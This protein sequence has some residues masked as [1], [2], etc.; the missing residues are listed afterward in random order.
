MTESTR[1]L[2]IK[3]KALIDTPSKWCRD[4]YARDAAGEKIKLV[5]DPR[6]V[7]WCIMGALRAVALRCTDRRW[8][9]TYTACS[10]VVR[11]VSSPSDFVKFNDDPATTHADI[12]ALFD[13]AI[14]SCDEDNQN[15]QQQV[16]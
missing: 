4:S 6:V 13:R 12:M 10:D 8:E 7:S 15:E 1:E 16:R 2:L 14:E 9:T 11:R 5:C 3:A